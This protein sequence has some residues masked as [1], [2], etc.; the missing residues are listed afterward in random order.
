VVNEGAE[1]EGEA[2]GA[3]VGLRGHTRSGLLCQRRFTVIWHIADNP[4]VPAFVR[5]WTKADKVGL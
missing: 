2:E 1:G 4:T 5:F 3:G